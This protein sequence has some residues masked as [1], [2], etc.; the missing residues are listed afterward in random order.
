MT[1]YAVVLQLNPDPNL[2]FVLGLESVAN[3]QRPHVVV[4]DKENFRKQLKAEMESQGI[5]CMVIIGPKEF[6]LNNP[7]RL[8]EAD[9]PDLPENDEEVVVSFGD[10]WWGYVHV[11][12]TL[13]VKRYFGPEDITDAIDSE[14]V[15]HVINPF[16]A[17]GAEQAA[18]L[19]KTR[20]DNGTY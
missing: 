15:A 19:A 8:S 5:T 20:W 9:F 10:P 17:T 14:F 6:L 18:K 3:I 4:G 13:H 2:N 16:H 7:F 12:G 1:E 11:D